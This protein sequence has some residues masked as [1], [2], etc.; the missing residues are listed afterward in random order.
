MAWRFFD[1]CSPAGNNL[2]EDWRVALSG[3]ARADFDVVLKELSILHDWHNNS[4][5]FK[6]LGKNGLCEIRFKCDGVQYRPAGFFGPES[7]S[8]S[9]YVGCHKKGKIYDPPDAFTRALRRK[10]QLDRGQGSL[11]E[12]V[13]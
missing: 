13:I 11:K 6:S 9:I 2:I 1:Y 10:S 3:N 8:F 4:K 12:R 5:S 7:K